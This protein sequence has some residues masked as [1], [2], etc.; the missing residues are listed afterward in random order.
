MQHHVRMT[1]THGQLFTA[2][3]AARACGVSRTTISRAA[4]A[5]R[6]EGA[7]RDEAGAWTL[8]LSGLLAG[9][10]NPGKPSP[11]DPA[12]EP[13][14]RDQSDEL[15]RLRAELADAHM[16]SQMLTV[17]LDA[18]RQMRESDAR[19]LDAVT[20]ERDLYRRMIEAPPQ[21][22]PE[23]PPTSATPDPD[24]IL[25][26]DPVGPSQAKIGRFRRAWNVAR[27]G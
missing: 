5:G 14:D 23:S 20:S 27:F 2:G 18:E 17:Q 11:P 13:E 6:I 21:Q 8:P 15:R 12:P 1:T 3:E 16:R 24:P 4:A 26:P 25:S 19:T 7:K 10:F 22:A 9:G